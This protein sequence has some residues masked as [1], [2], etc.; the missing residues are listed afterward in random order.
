[1]DIEKTIKIDLMETEFNARF[2]FTF[3]RGYAGSYF[4][5]P[6]GPSVAISAIALSDKT[7]KPLECPD[8]LHDLIAESEWIADELIDYAREDA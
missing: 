8:W 7:G 4:E 5:P 2:T 6:E 1:M 3:D